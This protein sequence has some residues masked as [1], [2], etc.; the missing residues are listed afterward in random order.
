MVF[1]NFVSLLTS[2][3][4]LFLLGTVCLAEALPGVG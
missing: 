2:D 3:F 1:L 4:P